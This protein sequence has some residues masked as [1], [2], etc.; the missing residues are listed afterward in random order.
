MI[1]SW[2]SLGPSVARRGRVRN[3]IL[4]RRADIPARPAPD[5]ADCFCRRREERRE[6]RRRGRARPKN[7]ASGGGGQLKDE[8]RASAETFAEGVERAAHF[9]R[10][11]RARM[12]AETVT[13]L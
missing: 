7:E 4:G 6:K 1:H 12:Q 5:K 8:G 13:G 10:G 11:Q 9:L 3:R 2:G